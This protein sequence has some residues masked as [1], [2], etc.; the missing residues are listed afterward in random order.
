MAS[1]PGPRC[2][3]SIPP[4][5][6]QYWYRL[7]LLRLDGEEDILR[8]I[9]VVVPNVGRSAQL[10]IPLVPS[11]GTPIE[12]RFKITGATSPVSLDIFDTR[13]R[14]IRSLDRRVR[15]PGV[16]LLTWDRTSETGVE[17]S[18]GVYFIQLRA[19]GTGQQSRKLVV[20]PR[21]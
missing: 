21:R 11:D 17:V 3:S 15:P 13:G 2:P 20:G 5:G 16:H 4:P 19:R 18:R 12:I 1:G 14:L 10:Y 6:R 7:R 8:P 9:A